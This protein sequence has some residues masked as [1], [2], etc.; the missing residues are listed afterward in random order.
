MTDATG[1]MER[2]QAV[3]EDAPRYTVLG[4][5]TRVIGQ[6]VEVTSLPVAVGDVCRIAPDDRTGILAQV[7]GFHER[8]VLLMPLGE[9][10]GIRPGDM[11]TPLGRGFFAQAGEQ[12]IGR[13]LDGLGTGVSGG[14]V[15]VIL[16]AMAGG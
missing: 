5:V 10:E 13:V 2:T 3:L 8:G 15:L 7:A 16:P 14:D 9:L 1:W 12:M 11:V 4:R 6:V